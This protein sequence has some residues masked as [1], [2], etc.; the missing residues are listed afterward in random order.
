MD[1]LRIDPSLLRIDPEAFVAENATV[2]GDVHIGKG[3]SIWFTA[4]IRG[5]VEEIRIGANTNIQDGAVIHADPGNPTIIGDDCTVGHRAIVHGARVGDR[6]LIGMGATVMNG[7]VVG[8]ECIIGANALVREGQQIP[9]RS[10][11]VGMPAKV[12]RS[13]AEH[14]IAMLSLSAQHYAASGQAYKEAGFG[15]PTPSCP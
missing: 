8:E 2:I 14:E 1:Y 13:L 9:P 11:V 4:V 5:D 12:I 6:A 10:L 3:A 15:K 7:A